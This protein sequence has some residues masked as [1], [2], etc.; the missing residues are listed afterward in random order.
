MDRLVL[1]QVVAEF[2]LLKILPTVLTEVSASLNEETHPTG[3]TKYFCEYSK[4]QT[5]KCLKRYFN[6][7]LYD[8]LE[9][10]A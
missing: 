5:K 9:K 8:Q 4:L 3:W 6:C 10:F 2:E 7:D 1:M